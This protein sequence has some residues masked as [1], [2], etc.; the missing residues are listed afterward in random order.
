MKNKLGDHRSGVDISILMHADMPLYPGDAPP[1]VRR[2]SS[3]SNGSPL[4]SSE[5]AMGCHVGTHVDAP[6][7][8]VNRGA[9]IDQLDLRHFYGN[10]VVLEFPGLNRITAEDVRD[11]EIRSGWHILLKTRNSA[12]LRQPHFDPQYCYVTPEAVRALLAFQPLS[13]GFD[14][15]SLDPPSTTDFPA[16]IEVAR[17]GIPVFVCLDLSDAS[18][19][20]YL[21]TALPLRVTNV[22]GI[23]V[24]AVLFR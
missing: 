19:G 3:I 23:P 1:Q 13:L 21:F 24:R 18:P 11:L 20:E 12:L 6:A 5:L 9:T 4:T 2:L 14:Y 8:F 22:E 10:A 17:S 7:H 16:H 15:Y